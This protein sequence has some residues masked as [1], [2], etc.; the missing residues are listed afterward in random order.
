M[1][2]TFVGAALIVA[3]AIA[4]ALVLI[5]LDKRWGDDSQQQS[6]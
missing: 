3:G 1:K 5:A 2:I 6:A 4:V